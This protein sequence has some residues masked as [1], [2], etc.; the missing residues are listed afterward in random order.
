MAKRQKLN[1][2]TEELAKDLKQSV[3]G[4]GLDAFFTPPPPASDFTE[5]KKNDTTNKDESGALIQ[6][7]TLSQKDDSVKETGRA[8]AQPKKTE[9]EIAVK[10]EPKRKVGAYFTKSERQNL[11]DLDYMLNRGDHVI[12]Q[13]EIIALSVE[14]L[15]SMLKSSNKRFSS[16]QKLR[17]YIDSLLAKEKAR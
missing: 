16:A 11:K 14:T 4:K 3:K 12:G 7:E 6:P 17:E 9:R 8:S 2:P 1:F 13:S 15:L 10:K 5:Q